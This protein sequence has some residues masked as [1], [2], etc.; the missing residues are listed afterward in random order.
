MA[1]QSV[2][3]VEGL[4]AGYGKTKIVE[5]VSFEL[6][7]GSVLGVLGRNGVGKTTTLKA[8]MGH[9]PH[10]GS[11]RL[12]GVDLSRLKAHERAAAGLAYVPQGRRIFA[13]L[14]VEDN[15]RI[16]VP[17]AR[18]SAWQAE[19]ENMYDQFPILAEKRRQAGGQL[20]GGQQQILALGRAL[21]AQPKVIL[22][23][24]PSE[25]IQPSIVEQIGQTI[26]TLCTEREIAVVLV[27]QNLGFATSVCDTVVLIDSGRIVMRTE[28]Q[29]I[30]DDREL[31]LQYLGV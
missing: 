29:T 4:H 14:S 7:A 5:D 18:R 20:S 17:R 31:Q 28:P 26:G 16:A 24:E 2:L 6:A 1:A 12:D 21:I 15:M 27:E 10:T 11:V 3:S 23:D 8:M 13:S 9:L 19:V 25:G 30:A 22:L